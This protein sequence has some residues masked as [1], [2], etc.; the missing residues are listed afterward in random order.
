MNRLSQVRGETLRFYGR[1][2]VDGRA[3]I[4]T[5]DNFLDVRSLDHTMRVDIHGRVDVDG[6]SLDRGRGRDNLHILP[7]WLIGF[8]NILRNLDR[9]ISGRGKR[10][11]NLDRVDRLDGLLL[12]HIS[13]VRGKVAV[14]DNGRNILDLNLDRDILHRRSSDGHMD[15]LEDSLVLEPDLLKIF[16]IETVAL[17]VSIVDAHF[18]FLEGDLLNPRRLHIAFSRT[19]D[20]GDGACRGFER[21]KPGAGRQRVCLCGR[22]V[23][24]FVS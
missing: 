17:L 6:R 20:T 10:R 7:F 19:K 9:S 23:G 3:V 15:R 5:E 11:L 13:H 8:R 14:G 12:R 16:I 4:L 1:G 18:G 21:Y 2:D 22:R 24:F